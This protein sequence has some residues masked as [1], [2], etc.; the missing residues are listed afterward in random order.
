VK[1]VADWP[2]STF[3]RYVQS[4][5]YPVDWMSDPSKDFGE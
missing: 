4:G 2:W 3:H 5:V 1:R